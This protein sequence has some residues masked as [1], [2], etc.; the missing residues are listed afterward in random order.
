V[1]T[2][3][4]WWFGRRRPVSRQT[5]QMEGKPVHRQQ[6]AL[7][8]AARKA[9]ATDDATGA[10]SALLEWARLQWPEQAPRSLG[11]IAA[12]VSEPLASELMALNRVSY[13]P[14][15]ANWEGTALG[16]ALR[17]ICI[18]ERFREEPGETAPGGTLP[19]LMPQ[20]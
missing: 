17:S 3:V 8:K 10:R 16:S 18:D 15:G 1:L 19:P 13:G 20:L 11:D 12:R 7:L 9:A 5:L 2:L 6:S 4:A 14:A